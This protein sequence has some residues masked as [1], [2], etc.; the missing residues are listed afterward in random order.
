MSGGPWTVD[1]YRTSTE[2]RPVRDFLAGLSKAAKPRVYAVLAMLEERGNQLLM[3]H[4]RPLGDGLYEIRVP[5]PEG[6]FRV[7]YCFRPGRRIVLLHGFVK[8][9]RKTPKEELDLARQRKRA[10]EREED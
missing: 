3:P 4:S 2:G 9:G 5:H 7:I 6:P 10:L 8:R 1:D